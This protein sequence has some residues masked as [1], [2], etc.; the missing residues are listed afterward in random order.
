M[1]RPHDGIIDGIVDSA[2][3]MVG[4]SDALPFDRV[5]AVMAAYHREEFAQN[6][7]IIKLLKSL[8]SKNGNGTRK[9]DKAKALVIPSGVAIV[10]IVEFLRVAGTL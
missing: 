4:T 8:N 7:E 9:R 3:K 6:E 5:V 1:T 2:Q 10:L